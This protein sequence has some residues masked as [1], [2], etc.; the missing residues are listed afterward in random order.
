MAVRAHP[1]LTKP[2]LFLDDYVIC[3]ADNFRR[4]PG[5]TIAHAAIEAVFHFADRIYQYCLQNDQ[6]GLLNGKC[7]RTF[8]NELI[9]TEPDMKLADRVANAGKHHLIVRD[10]IEYTASG[11][12]FSEAGVFWICSENGEK[13]RTVDEFLTSAIAMWRHWQSAHPGL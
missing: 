6:L 4:R 13:L 9:A 10:S 3:A 8:R 11:Q 5:E 7:F 2:S 12:F 1:T